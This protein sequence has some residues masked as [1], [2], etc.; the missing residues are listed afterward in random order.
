MKRTLIG[1]ALL[2]LVAMGVYAV[3]AVNRGRASGA[4]ATQ[5]DAGNACGPS[6]AAASGESAGGKIAGRF[7]PAMSGPCRFACATKLEHDPKDVLAQPGAMAGK[8]TQ[9]PVSGVVFA[10]DAERPHVR[11]AGEDYV[12][13]CGSCAGKLE[14]DPGRYLKL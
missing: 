14:R 9:C 2:A 6:G 11:I 1:L 7:D 10:V 13:C 4:G 5:A 8:L 3:I 12:T